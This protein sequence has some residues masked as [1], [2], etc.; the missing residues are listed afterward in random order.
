[1]SEVDTWTI[2]LLALVT[3]L[4]V[5]VMMK[6]M[7]KFRL[8]ILNVFL[9]LL[10]GSFTLIDI[11]RYPPLRIDWHILGYTPIFLVNGTIIVGTWTLDW[12]QVFILLC[13]IIDV[14]RFLTSRFT[15]QGAKR[16]PSGG[17]DLEN[18]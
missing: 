7:N 3:V 6:F 1:V 4:I 15:I 9:L 12:F 18:V 8:I 5:G 10:G 16:A 13:V 2:P 14:Y 17:R 11:S